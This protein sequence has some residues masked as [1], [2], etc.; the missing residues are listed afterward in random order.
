MKL[1]ILLLLITLSAHTIAADNTTKGHGYTFAIPEGWSVRYRADD[2]S[3]IILCNYPKDK[4][5]PEK[6]TTILMKTERYS[7]EVTR[8]FLGKTGKQSK[9]IGTAEVRFKTRKDE[10]ILGSGA[11]RVSLE[12]TWLIYHILREETYTMIRMRALTSQLG[13][14]KSAL[15]Q[16]MK[17]IRLEKAG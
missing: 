1:C 9:S 11:S 4:P 2:I 6:E 13:G 17:S 10:R 15:G 5:S 16:L 3:R 8:E 14:V 12:E 7:S